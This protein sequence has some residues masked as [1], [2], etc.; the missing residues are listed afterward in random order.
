MSATPYVSFVTYGRNDGY[1]PSYVRRVSRA[2]ACL[3]H[4]LDRAGVDA[5]IIIADWNPPSDRPLLI[6]Q[7]GVPKALR[8]VSIRGLIV[9]P[10]HHN[11]FVGAAERGIHAG[12]AA[13]V[14]LRRARGRFATPKAS[15]TFFSPQ[16]IAMLARRDL[17]EGTMYRIDRHD[18]VVE[19]EAIWELDDDALLAAL[20]RMPSVPHA[21]IEQSEHWGLR[22]LHT[23]A[24]G[25]FTLMSLAH[26][27]RLRGHPYDASVLT[28]DIDSLVMHAAAALGVR[29]RRW[30]DDCRVYKPSHGNLSNARVTQVW[31]GWQRTLDRF[32]SQKVGQPAALRARILFDYP[33]RKIRG[34]ESVIGPSI[35]RNFVQ[36]ASRWALGDGP[37]PSQP[38]SWGL[39]DV[40]LE[41]RT[42]C[43][44]EW[45]T[46]PA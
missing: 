26:W 40:A 46:V 22:N 14:G 3:A 45:E 5:E 29:E 32:L 8:H 17:D 38:E 10:E 31:T 42:L 24:C 15:D 16:T 35:E 4:Q 27:H 41:E 18:V 36:P 6:D 44:A 21:W 28:L 13:N 7:L 2:T 25:D 37:S 33:R 43:N 20:A 23:N 1:T 19:D 34:V 39:A 30:P 12:E 9:A 11:A